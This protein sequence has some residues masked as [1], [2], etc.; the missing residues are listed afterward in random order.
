ML[1][2][3][4]FCICEW[5]KLCAYCDRC[6]KCQITDCQIDDEFIDEIINIVWVQALVPINF[7]YISWKILIKYAENYDKGWCVEEHWGNNNFWMKHK[8]II[9]KQYENQPNPI[10]QDEILKAAVMKYGKNQWSRIASLLHR[11]SGKFLD[12]YSKIKC[13]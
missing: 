10:S 3:L 8:I 13:S 6:T 5:G 9:Y 11:K 4:N 7:R 1:H 12:I 2:C